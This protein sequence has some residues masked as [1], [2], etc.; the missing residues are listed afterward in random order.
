MY[1]M[2]VQNGMQQKNGGHSPKK[3]KLSKMH[4]N[5]KTK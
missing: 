1:N 3:L 4:G 5:A 2:C